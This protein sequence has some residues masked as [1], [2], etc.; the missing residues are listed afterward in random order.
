VPG[1]REPLRVMLFHPHMKPLTSFAS[2]LR[3]RGSVEV[4]KF[5]PLDGGIN[6]QILFLFEK[7]GPMTAE[8]GGSGFISRNNDDLTAEATFKFM[9]QAGIPRE[10]TITWNVIPWWNGTRKVTGQELREGVAC[11]RELISLLPKL[12]AVVLVG[13]KAARAR[14]YLE[15]KGLAVFTS[16]HP[17][18]LVRA[19]SPDKWD[20]IPEEWAKAF[21]FIKDALFAR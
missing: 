11:V 4:P 21:A 8:A 1:E 20:A 9:E 13:G 10:L 2:K 16:A 14:V 17:L 7:P 5:A 12:Q 3:Q 6:A 18:P 15:G 19:K